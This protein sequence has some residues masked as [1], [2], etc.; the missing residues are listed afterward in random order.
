MMDEETTAGAFTCCR[1]QREFPVSDARTVRSK[2]LGLLRLSGMPLP[3]LN[4]NAYL[5][6]RRC[7]R[8]ENTG[9]LFLA[10]I[11]FGGTILVILA[12]LFKWK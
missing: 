11:G 9:V 2:F 10:A 7:A 1:C 8:S 4:E 6:C 3:D 12:W 5:Y